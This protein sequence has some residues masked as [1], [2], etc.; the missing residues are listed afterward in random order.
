MMPADL[1]ALDM[2]NLRKRKYK[3]PISNEKFPTLLIIKDLQIKEKMWF[4]YQISKDYQI[5][6][7]AWGF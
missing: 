5:K 4:T 2:D 6:V 1:W 3:W 7:K